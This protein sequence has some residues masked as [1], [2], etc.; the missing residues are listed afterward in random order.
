MTELTTPASPPNA[1][2]QV[3]SES[4]TTGSAPAIWSSGVKPRPSAAGVR[5]TWK[6]FHSTAVASMDRVPSPDPATSSR[7]L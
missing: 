4:T 2:C 7:S 1:D 5:V 3:A 6:M